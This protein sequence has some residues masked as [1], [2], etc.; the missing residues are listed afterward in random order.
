MR[1]EQCK[2]RREKNSILSC[3]LTFINSTIKTRVTTLMSCRLLPVNRARRHDVNVAKEPSQRPIEQ[4]IWA[5]SE[6]RVGSPVTKQAS[7]V[8]DFVKYNECDFKGATTTSAAER[9]GFRS[10]LMKNSIVPRKSFKM[11]CA[12]F[13]YDVTFRV[14]NARTKAHRK[15]RPVTKAERYRMMMDTTTGGDVQK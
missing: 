7:C 5:Q 14:N 10:R 15:G 3:V 11:C 13:L 1:G 4:L 2:R 8:P 12:T 6:N 9:N